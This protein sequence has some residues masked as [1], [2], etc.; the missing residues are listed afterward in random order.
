MTSSNSSYLL[1][2]LLAMFDYEDVPRIVF[3]FPYTSENSPATNASF[4]PPG[5]EAL[6]ESVLLDS[7]LMYSYMLN[8]DKQSGKLL[9]SVDQLL[10]LGHV[11]VISDKRCSFV[12]LLR[13]DT[14]VLVL[15]R[16]YEMSRLIAQVYTILEM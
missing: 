11:E 7:L 12:F 13:A 1:H 2:I 6:S 14:P 16:F 8:S 5:D 9:L 3:R 10:L 15:D 4:P